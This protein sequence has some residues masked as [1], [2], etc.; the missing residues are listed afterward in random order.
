M[1]TVNLGFPYHLPC[2]SIGCLRFERMGTTMLTGQL[3]HGTQKSVGEIANDE[4]IYASDIQ[5]F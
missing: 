3:V 4:P 5:S 2:T 1:V